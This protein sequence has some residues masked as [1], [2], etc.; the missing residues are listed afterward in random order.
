MDS[1]MITEVLARIID[2][3]VVLSNLK[4]SVPV[5]VDVARTCWD[6]LRADWTG[7][8]NVLAVADCSGL[9]ANLDPHDSVSKFVTFDKIWTC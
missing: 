4:L 6:Y 8:R 7:L 5:A 2:H 3:Q 1:R 9:L